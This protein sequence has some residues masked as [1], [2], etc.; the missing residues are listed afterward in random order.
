VTGTAALPQI[1]TSDQIAP[2]VGI[3]SKTSR[4]QEVPSRKVSQGLVGTGLR[5]RSP[6]TT[7]GVCG[8]VDQQITNRRDGLAQARDLKNSVG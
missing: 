1:K 5:L 6:L 8:S 3:L 2:G 7:D 4:V